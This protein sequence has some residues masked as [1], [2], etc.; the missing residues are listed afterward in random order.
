MDDDNGAADPE[1]TPP[2]DTP[3]PQSHATELNLAITAAGTLAQVMHAHAIAAGD[4]ERL[5]RAV[6]PRLTFW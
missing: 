5:R 3:Q 6:K 1:P 2:D 4:L